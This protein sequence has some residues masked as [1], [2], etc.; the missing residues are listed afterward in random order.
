[1]DASIGGIHKLR[2]KARGERGVSHY[3]ISLTSK[4]VNEEGGVKNSVNVV[5]GCPLSHPSQVIPY[6]DT[7]RAPQQD[8]FT[9]VM[10]Q[11]VNS[12]GLKCVM[13][14]DET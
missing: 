6:N 2:L 4:L 3:F 1:M 5:Y 9:F 7:K 11:R 8:H 12:T 10:R 13:Y 14:C